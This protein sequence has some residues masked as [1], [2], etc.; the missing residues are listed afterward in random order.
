MSRRRIACLHPD[1]DLPDPKRFDRFR[2]KGGLLLAIMSNGFGSVEEARESVRA[3]KRANADHAKAERERIKRLNSPV[4]PGPDGED[5]G[6]DLGPAALARGK[7]ER[8]GGTIRH[9][10]QRKA[11]PVHARK[12]EQTDLFARMNSVGQLSDRQA[13]AGH[14][15]LRLK[16][17]AGLDPRVTARYQVVHD[18][19]GDD[20]DDTEI[21]EAICPPEFDPR[22]YHRHLLRRLPA[23]S[24]FLID[25][26]CD[27]TLEHQ[28]GHPGVRFLATF[29]EGLS[30]LADILRIKDE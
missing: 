19:S 6:M 10:A 29:Q 3:R 7:I 4:P 2:A 12:V 27:W 1:P 20:D 13:K 15:I 21:I 22:S 16:R 25:R 11:V 17:A 8:V 9:S 18:R 23:Q 14:T 5:H 28:V 26:A 24:A 30:R